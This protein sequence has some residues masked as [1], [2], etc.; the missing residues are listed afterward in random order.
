M[1]TKQMFKVLQ[2]VDTKTGGFWSRIGTGFRNRD[3]SINIMLNSLP[4]NGEV[5]LRE[6]DEEDHKRMA[7]YAARGNAASPMPPSVSAPAATREDT[8]PF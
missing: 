8:I 7:S 5:Q 1:Q 2:R 3:D 4:I 6:L